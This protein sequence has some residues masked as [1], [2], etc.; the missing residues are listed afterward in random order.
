MSEEQLRAIGRLSTKTKRDKYNR[1]PVQ[2][3]TVDGIIFDSKKEMNYY[4]KLKIDPDIKF[5][6]RQVPFDIPGGYKHRVDFM[7]VMKDGSIRWIEV[8]G[9]DLPQGK[10]KRKQVESIYNITIE[11]V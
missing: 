9:M 1:S 7:A 8:K 2:E 3:R 10:M 4:L 6:L 11:V 5:F